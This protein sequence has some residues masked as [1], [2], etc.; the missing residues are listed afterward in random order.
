M[1][2]LSLVQELEEIIKTV[3]TLFPNANYK[4]YETI[5]INQYSL[6]KELNPVAHI[7]ISSNHFLVTILEKGKLIFN[8]KFNFFIN[9]SP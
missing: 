9:Y 6:V 1:R 5:L 4:S 7:D 3:K 8:N 2:F